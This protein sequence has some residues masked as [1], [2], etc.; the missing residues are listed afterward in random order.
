MN[1]Q[2]IVYSTRSSL[3]RRAI[4][5]QRRWIEERL[6]TPLAETVVFETR[7]NFSQIG[8]EKILGCRDQ[9]LELPR[10]VRRLQPFVTAAEI[11]P[12]C[13]PL[14]SIERLPPI[15][16]NIC[17]ILG[18]TPAENTKV[19]W[20]DCPI[21][22][23][24]RFLPSP[25]VV[26]NVPYLSGPASDV[27][28]RTSLLIARRDCAPRVARLLG[29]LDRREGKARL[30]T[31]NGSTRE[32]SGCAWEDLVLDPS[33]ASLL[34]DDFENFWKREAWFRERRIP[35]RRGYL[36]HGPPGNGKSSAIRAMACSHQMSAFT[37]R[38][39]DPR[40]SDSDLDDL[41]DAALKERPAL[42]L[43]E[44]LDRA[45]PTGG[46][47]AT[48]ISL[49]YLLNCLDGVA[50]GKGVVVVATANQPA[51][52]ESAI[53]RRPGRF[54]RVV[55]FPN[56]SAQ[57]REAYFCHMNADFRAT[58]L[59]PAV[60]ESEGYSFA[61]LREAYVLASQAAFGRGDDLRSDDLL[62]GV[63]VL[64]QGVLQGSENS[65]AA[66]FRPET[67]GDAP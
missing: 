10:A 18:E 7:I 37:I 35:F 9:S 63:R 25:V 22:L 45:F 2:R 43:L 42:V 17:E 30:H 41:F 46:K 51:L 32:I 48:N 40:T 56:P 66:G 54:D 49:Q 6:R 19:E 52:L 3:L 44:D 31:L 12:D 27:E 29:N 23:Q 47:S 61:Q 38:L 11:P 34:R 60:G 26:L 4:G 64:R 24:L 65:H 16:R 39:F 1:A 5:E 15:A 13:P 14:L 53:L 36:L 8:V 33:I 50:T 67:A 58:D 28:N 20:G 21:A 62:S 57:L 59:A 55:K